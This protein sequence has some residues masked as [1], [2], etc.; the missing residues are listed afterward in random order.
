MI[1]YDPA[2]RVGAGPRGRDRR[3]RLASS[4]RARGREIAALSCT[5]AREHM[6]RVG[7][8]PPCPQRFARRQAIMRRPSEGSFAFLRSFARR[9]IGAESRHSRMPLTDYSA[10]QSN[11]PCPPNYPLQEAGA[12]LADVE[13][14]RA[15]MRRVIRE[16]RGHYHLW[17]C[18]GAAWIAMPS[19]RISGRQRR[20]VLSVDLRQ[21]RPAVL[22]HRLH[23]VGR[24]AGPRMA[25]SSPSWSRSGALA[26]SF[27]SCSTPLSTTASHVCVLL[28]HRDADV[29]IVA[30]L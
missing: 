18:W 26:R 21:R 10:L 8:C 3:Q 14:T 29:C 4:S 20:A 13:T 16:H 5:R 25:A 1:P 9:Q 15:A 17:I 7:L 22:P 11:L 2:E 19:P 28:P 12:L 30:G 27:P 23:A 24:F 6:Q